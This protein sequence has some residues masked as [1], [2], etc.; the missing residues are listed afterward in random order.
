MRMIVIED[1]YAAWRDA[2]LE[3]LAAGAPPDTL[4]WRLARDAERL[5]DQA[6]L[7]YCRGIDGGGAAGLAEAAV[8]RPF[9]AAPVHVSKELSALMQEAALFRDPQRWAFLYKVLCAGYRGTARLHPLP[10]RTA[11]ACRAWRAPCGAT[12]T[13]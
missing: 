1:H 4:E 6:T 3:A 11:R 2:A 10:M 12:S 5:Q 9:P 7:D 8:R 13:T